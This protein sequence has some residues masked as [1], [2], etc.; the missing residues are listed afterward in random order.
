MK[1]SVEHS[2]R[3]LNECRAEITSLK[4]ELESLMASRTLRSTQNT[5]AEAAVAQLERISSAAVTGSTVVQLDPTLNAAVKNPDADSKSEARSLVPEGPI[6]VE[7][8][9]ASPFESIG[10][11]EEFGFVEDILVVILENSMTLIDSNG[12]MASGEQDIREDTLST[13][14]HVSSRE[15][16]IEHEPVCFT[17]LHCFAFICWGWYTFI[18]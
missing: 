15:S 4:L 5:E 9:M 14:A 17:I 13:H 7:N 11:N 6:T 2:S 1:E 8:M 10:A 18:F 16:E 12:Y 3:L